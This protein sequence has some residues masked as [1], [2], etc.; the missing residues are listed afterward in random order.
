[1][2]YTIDNAGEGEKIPKGD[3]VVL[4]CNVKA[5]KGQSPASIP[6]NPMPVSQMTKGLQEGLFMLGKGGK[7]TF[8][9]PAKL[10]YDAETAK[11]MNLEPNTVFIY[12]VEVL[13]IPAI[14]ATNNA[15]PAV[16]PVAR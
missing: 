10:A 4:K 12:E 6:S 14:P 13:D 16:V 15:A 9:V 1:M 7:A 2:V 8:Y 3:R 11:R 5:L